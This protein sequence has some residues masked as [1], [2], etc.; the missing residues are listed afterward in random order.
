MENLRIR[1][2]QKR[3]DSALTRIIRKALGEFDADR[4]GFA[5]HDPETRAMYAAYRARRRAFYVVVTSTGQ[6]VGGGGIAPLGGGRPGTCELR[7][8]YFLRSIR[9]RGMGRRLLRRCLRRAK[10][11]GYAQC[12]LETLARMK[13]A[14][15]LYESEGFREIPAPR[16]KTGHFGCDAWY[17]KRL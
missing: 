7:K 5:S 14:R 15:R 12:Y 4:P 2:I 6:V 3:D 1:A 17:L 10:A 16:G 11:L 8:M 13:A 9:G